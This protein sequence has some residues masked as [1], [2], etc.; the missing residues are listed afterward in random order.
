MHFDCILLYLGIALV[1]DHSAENDITDYV[2]LQGKIDH[3]HKNCPFSYLKVT[4]L[5]K[6]QYSVV[7]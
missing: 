1:S 4:S 2:I 3:D 5:E 7:F 6:L